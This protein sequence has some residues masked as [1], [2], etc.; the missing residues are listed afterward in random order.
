ML[1]PGEAMSPPSDPQAPPPVQV[2]DSRWAGR[3]RRWAIDL[4]IVITVFAGL[5]WW[6]TRDVVRGALPALD[7]PMVNAASAGQWRA[8]HASEGFVLYVWATWCPICKTVEGSIDS[9][10]R[11]A[12]L[13]TVA[14]NS[15]DA[16]AVERFLQSRQHR[17]PTLVDGDG[18]L[19]HGLGVDAVPTLIFVDR[20]GRVSSVTR[21]YTTELGIRAR[22]WWARRAS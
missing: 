7:A 8:A 1:R 19:S 17:W 3:L 2:G 15:G 6:M 10:A 18:K 21:G 13:L 9:V 20:H 14:M 4:G 16:A 11:D 5:Q 22:L 12:P